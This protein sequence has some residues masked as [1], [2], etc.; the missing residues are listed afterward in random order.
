MKKKLP[1]GSIVKLNNNKRFMIIGYSP[2]KPNDKEIFDYICCLP[3]IGI[4]RKASEIKLNIDY[5]YIKEEDIKQVLYIGYSDKI[6]DLYEYSLYIC[7]TNLKI[8]KDQEE[9]INEENIKKI[10]EQSF[11]DI[12]RV[13]EGNG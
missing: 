3:K 13:G 7:E 4:I 8:V 5:F 11:E 2:N 12:K 1:V 6:F 10:V 9:E